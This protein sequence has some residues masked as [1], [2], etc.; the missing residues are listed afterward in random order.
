MPV[1]ILPAVT[2]G[3][4][5]GV[6]G[7]LLF[8]LA[9]AL[10]IVP[11]WNRMGSGILFGALAGAAAGWAFAEMH[12]QAARN[13]SASGVIAGAG[14][15]A[16]LWLAAAPVTAA[17]AALRALG[18]AARFELV[19]V[20]VALALAVGDGLLLGWVTT[21][22]RR[23]AIAAAV[24]VLLL[25]VAMAGPVPVGRSIRAFNIFLAVLPAAVLAGVVLALLAPS[26]LTWTA[27]RERERTPGSTEP[28][29]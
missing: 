11:I 28:G 27:R 29:D 13:R 18:L 16:L 10:L 1:E 14:F 6:A 25:V 12:P 23:G 20:G 9:H 17:D 26:I 5:S 19:A 24:A 2:A 22:R 4:L 8:A 21:H 15:G 7:A 3:V